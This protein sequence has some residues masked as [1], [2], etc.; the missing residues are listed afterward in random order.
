MDKNKIRTLK[1][2]RM[3]KIRFFF[4]FLL[5]IF[6]VHTIKAQDGNNPPPQASQ[7]NFWIGKWDLYAD[8]TLM[9]ENTVT[10][11]LDGYAVQDNFVEFPPDPFHGVSIS[12][13]NSETNKWE[14]TM[15]DNK[16]HHSLFTGEFKEGKMILIRDY[17]NKKGEPRKQR[18]SFINITRNDFD[19]TFEIST[20]NGATW[21]VLY[22]VHYKRKM[23]Q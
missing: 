2:Y 10:S 3:Q 15:V 5:Y 6:P 18:T 8:N 13:Y 23:I 7:F 20:N 9:G 17:L 11:I 21:E 19:W 4:I 12:S 14:Q 1:I 16:G 22:N